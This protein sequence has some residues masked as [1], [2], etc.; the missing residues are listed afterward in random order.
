MIN[1]FKINENEFEKLAYEYMTA[2]YPDLDW[3]STKLTR[4]GNKDGEAIYAAPVNITIKYWYEAKYT[5]AINKSIPKSHLDSTLVSSLLDGKVVVIAFIT[6][7]YISDDYR[8]RADT[9]S[10]QRDNLQIIYVNGN[11][12]EQWLSENPSIEFN[13]FGETFAKEQNIVSCI[14]K[15]YL[16]QD[17][18]F[19]GHHY[20][21]VKNIESN[22]TYIL[23]VSFYSACVQQLGIIAISKNVR[24]LGLEN[25]KYDNYDMLNAHIG[26]N[27]FYIPVSF[28]KNDVDSISFELQSSLNSYFFQI[29]D[30]SIIDVYDPNII[31]GSQIEIANKMY[32]LVESKD[33]VNAIFCIEGD[34]GSGK[35]YLLNTIFKNNNNPFA[36]FVICFTGNEKTDLLACYRIIVYSLYGDIWNYIDEQTDLNCFN[37]FETLMLTQLKNN[38]TDRTAYDSIVDYFGNTER[39]FEKDTNKN[40]ILIDDLHKLSPSNL[41]LLTVYLEWFIRQRFNCNIVIFS[42]PSTTTDIIKLCTKQYIIEAIM[43]EDVRATIKSNFPNLLFL[44]DAI[45]KYPTPLNAL[46]FLNIICEI[47]KKEDSFRKYTYLEMQIALNEIYSHSKDISYISFGDQLIQKYNKDPIAYFTYKIKTGIPIEAIVQYF[48]DSIYENIFELCQNRIV[49]ESSD[50]LFPYHDILTDA[51][52]N[53]RY[54]QIDH[55]LEKFVI[56]CENMHFLGKSKMFS[57]LLSMGKKCFLNYRYEASKYRDLLHSSADY[58]Q[59]LDIAEQIK[60]ANQK[61]LISYDFSDCQNQFVLANC[62]KYTESYAKANKEFQKICDVFHQKKDPKIRGLYLESETEIINNLIWMLEARQAKKKL[63]SLYPELHELYE[64]NLLRSKNEIYAFLN[65]FNRLMFV[66]YMLD[67]GSEK[68]YKNA[69]EYSKKMG[70]EVYIAFAKMDYGKCLYCSDLVIATRLMNDAV[71][72]LCKHDEEKRRLL[73][74][75]AEITFLDDLHNRKISY[76]KYYSLVQSAQQNHYV[77]SET[78]VHLKQIFLEILFHRYDT[79]YIRNQLEFISINSPTIATGKRHQ[80]YIYH[81]YAAAYYIDGNITEVHNYSR[82]CLLLMGKMGNNYQNIH[83]HNLSLTEYKGFTTIDC[84]NQG[85]NAEGKFIMDTRVW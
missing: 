3:I 74:A 43:A 34:A 19:S 21:E 11:E 84:F 28:F 2:K 63:K 54:E 68:D 12:I 75:T 57:V 24:F 83:K 72:I 38:Q 51:F 39:Y 31:Y 22:K 65:Y 4:D 41:K 78:K 80:A 18:D 14:K 42:R 59:A 61:T 37:N 7:A 30:I 53:I 29:N 81:L 56:F 45:E 44:H 71:S 6:N 17:F 8:R 27:S 36:S 1:W 85:H 60:K 77:Q 16:L 35:S 23:Y 48:G 52:D 13:Y 33:T 64:N 25:R 58:Y 76:E 55:E 46:H 15:A 82:K 62:I 67:N 49:R 32:A 73:D 79:E 70:I 20:R 9:F 66:N 5:K 50:S 69:V 40:L 47:H 10:R 26:Y